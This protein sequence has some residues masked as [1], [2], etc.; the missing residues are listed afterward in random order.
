MRGSKETNQVH[1]QFLVGLVLFK[2][3]VFYRSVF[4]LLSFVFC[5][6][7]CLS[8]NLQLLGIPLVFLNFS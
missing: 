4:F 6:L 2:S 7:Y 1:P 3:F 5:P 8:F